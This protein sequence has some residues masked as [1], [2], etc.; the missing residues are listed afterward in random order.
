V[1]TPAP[2][3]TAEEHTNVGSLFEDNVVVVGGAKSRWAR[4]RRIELEELV[5]EPWTLPPPG[6]S[7]GIIVATAFRARGLP[8]PEVTVVAESAII[9]NRLVGTGRFLTVF[10]EYSLRFSG[11]DPTLKVLPVEL[12]GARRTVRIV[13]L[14]NRSLSPL[15]ELFIDRMR[16]VTSA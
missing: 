9:L 15:A 3:P 5:N 12:P 8:P 6:S 1:I 16:A 10:S 7:L 11:I 14:K 13:S 4:R 2:G